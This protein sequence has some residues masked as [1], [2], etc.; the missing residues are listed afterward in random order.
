MVG[1][2]ERGDQQ[3]R[4]RS[5]IHWSQRRDVDGRRALASRTGDVT[6]AILEGRDCDIADPDVG[7][8]H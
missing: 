4:R 1:G 7:L 5:C 6:G 2:S 3:S 8:N